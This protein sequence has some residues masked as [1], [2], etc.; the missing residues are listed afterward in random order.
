M[1]QSCRPNID[2][3]LRRLRP[4]DHV[5]STSD[6]YGG[7][8]RLMTQIHQPM[9]VEFTFVDLAS[10]DALADASLL[11]FRTVAQLVRDANAAAAKWAEE[12]QYGRDPDLA[13][14][15]GQAEARDFI[16]RKKAALERELG[17]V[18]DQHLNE[19]DA[20]CNE[21]VTLQDV[22]D[23]AGTHSCVH[24]DT[25]TDGG[26][27]F[28]S[29]VPFAPPGRGRAPKL[30]AG[31]S[32]EGPSTT[33][34][35]NV[36]P[37]SSSAARMAE[38]MKAGLRAASVSDADRARAERTAYATGSS[39]LDSVPATS[40]GDFAIP[41]AEASATTQLNWL[42]ERCVEISGVEG[43]E[44]TATQLARALLS[45]APLARLC[46]IRLCEMRGEGLDSGISH[47]DGF[48]LRGVKCCGTG[49]ADRAFSRIRAVFG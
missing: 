12:A 2:A 44:E 15:R 3:I 28:G 32:P 17:P 1:W 19:F 47:G 18:S 14:K 45:H 49:P 39:P 41:A 26:W 9:G 23:P 40:G 13:K 21:L 42:K 11:A 25:G 36:Q 35:S 29:D 34:G 10:P 5:V 8:Y 30:S 46:G 27:E 7:T 6:L 20:A 31:R 38:Q 22:H 37:V 24:T 16:K 48:R 33:P 43:W 4:G